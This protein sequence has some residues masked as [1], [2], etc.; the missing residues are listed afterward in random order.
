[1]LVRILSAAFRKNLE[2]WNCNSRT[3]S[4]GPRRA[5]AGSMSFPYYE[6]YIPL[7]P[8][9]FL[10]AAKASKMPKS[11]QASLATYLQTNLFILSRQKANIYIYRERERGRQKGFTQQDLF[12]LPRQSTYLGKGIYL[13]YQGKRQK[14][15][16]IY[17]YIYVERKREREKVKKKTHWK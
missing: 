13:F 17:I 12:I 15:T 8:R 5:M 1:M 6:P 11:K 4:P 14:Q 16:Y 7:Y 9:G 2:G 10:V 3:H